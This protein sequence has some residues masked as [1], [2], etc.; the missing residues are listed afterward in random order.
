MQVGS[1]GQVSFGSGTDECCD[2][3]FPTAPPL[4]TA[5]W[6]D[7]DLRIGGTIYHRVINANDSELAVLGDS[8]RAIPGGQCL[9]F[10]PTSAAVIT[11]ERV[12]AFGG[13]SDIVCAAAI[14][15]VYNCDSILYF[16]QHNTFQ[17]ILL[18]NGSTS[19]SVF[20]YSNMTWGNDATIGFANNESFYTLKGGESVFVI[21]AK[22]TF[23]ELPSSTNVD[24]NGVYV[25]E[26][27]SSKPT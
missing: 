23:T 3:G 17:V 18:T 25:F 27:S 10:E 21:I 1:N 4:V 9:Q 16:L 5:F 22:S 15:F 20:L 11:Y 6:N 19:Y 13:S 8:L 26:T 12:S 14:S 2:R 24:V 7:I